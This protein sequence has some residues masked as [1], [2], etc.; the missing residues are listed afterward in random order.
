MLHYKYIVCLVAL[1]Y[2]QFFFR[3]EVFYSL[4]IRIKQNLNVCY[5]HKF[6]GVFSAFAKLRKLTISFIISVRPSARTK[7]L[8]SHRKDFHEI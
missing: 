4:T 6:I 1:Q 2:V 5:M 3:M 8:G 7:Q